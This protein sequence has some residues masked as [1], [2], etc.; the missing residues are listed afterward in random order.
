MVQRAVEHESGEK[1][2]LFDQY[3]I[4]KVL[5]YHLSIPEML[6]DFSNE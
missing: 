1:M 3:K 2:G 4:C 5:K 6:G